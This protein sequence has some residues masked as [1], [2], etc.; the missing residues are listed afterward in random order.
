MRGYE[1]FLFVLGQLFLVPKLRLGMPSSTL[2]VEYSSN[3]LV[4]EPEKKCLKLKLWTP[5]KMR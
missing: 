1:F 3:F 4:W 2:R 5:K